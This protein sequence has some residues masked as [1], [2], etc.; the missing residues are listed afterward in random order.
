MIQD[1]VETVDAALECSD[2]GEECFLGVCLGDL[3]RVP[4]ERPDVDIR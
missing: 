4:L 1:L 3:Q 2:H